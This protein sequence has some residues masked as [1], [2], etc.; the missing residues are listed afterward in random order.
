VLSTEIRA[1]Y[2]KANPKQ[3]RLLDAEIEKRFAAAEQAGTVESL[4]GFLELF[5]WHS[6]ATKARLAL[7]RKLPRPQ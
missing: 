3:R 7:A 6:I 5:R 1:L 2:A 4:R